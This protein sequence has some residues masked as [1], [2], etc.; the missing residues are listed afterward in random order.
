MEIESHGSLFKTD[1]ESI[2]TR[3]LEFVHCSVRSWRL[4]GKK[5]KHSSQHTAKTILFTILFTYLL[6]VRRFRNDDCMINVP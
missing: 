5:P 2:G 6:C 3:F 1:R 4:G